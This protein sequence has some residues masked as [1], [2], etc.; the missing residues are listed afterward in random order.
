M[1][2]NDIY[3]TE[4]LLNNT[5]SDVGKF[6]FN[7]LLTKARV[8]SVYDGDTVTIVFYHSSITNAPIK[9]NFRIHGYDSPELKPNKN[10]SNREMH[11]AS[12]IRAKKYLEE[13]ILNKVVW[14][15]FTNKDKY[16]RLMGNIYIVNE[17]CP[18]VFNGDEIC[19]SDVMINK[20]YGKQY[21]GGKKIEFSEQELLKTL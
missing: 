8:T 10:I 2:S 6:T 20:W 4:K 12:A 18:S 9:D 7:G 17:K 5:F 21:S 14:I 15:K 3:N 16:G 19:I 1:N 11:I 13:I